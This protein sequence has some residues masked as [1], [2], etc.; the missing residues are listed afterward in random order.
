MPI[1]RCCSQVSPSRMA[2][3]ALLLALSLRVLAVAAAWADPN[4]GELDLDYLVDQFKLAPDGKAMIVISNEAKKIAFL[5]L[6]DGTEAAGSLSYDHFFDRLCANVEISTMALD[7]AGRYAYFAGNLRCGRA[8]GFL[9]QLGWEDFSAKTIMLDEVLANP[10]IAVGSDGIVYLADRQSSTLSVIDPKRFQQDSTE[11]PRGKLGPSIYLPDGPAAALASS[12]DDRFVV[13]SHTRGRII[14]LIDRSTAQVVDKLGDKTSDR[15]PSVSIAV[16]SDPTGVFR[17]RSVLLIG[18]AQEDVFVLAGLE[19]DFGSMAVR[20]VTP[21]G[22]KPD[23]KELLSQDPVEPILKIG[24][25]PKA[26]L[27]VVGSK[28]KAE[29][30]VFDIE[31]GIPER[32]NVIALSKPPK[33]IEV[34]GDKAVFL[35]ADGRSFRVVTDPGKPEEKAAFLG[36]VRIRQAQEALA[37]LGYPVGVVDGFSGPRTQDILLRFQDAAGLKPTGELDDVTFK[38]LIEAAEK[39]ASSKMPN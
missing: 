31:K 39:K 19:T 8:V 2:V 34:D 33:Q 1:A 15:S 35:A 36:S 13:V 14:S 21:L 28:L 37:K 25:D 22:F 10:S 17:R 9:T 7:Q 32:V 20:S 27:A 26:R 4:P 29:A 3:R 24:V 18:D 11:I 12:G 16:P 38:A 6:S 5:K 23:E 30:Q